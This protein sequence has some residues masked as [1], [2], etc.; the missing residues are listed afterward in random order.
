MRQ[1]EVVADVLDGFVH[2]WGLPVAIG[3]AVLAIA[4]VGAW[5]YELHVVKHGR[6]GGTSMGDAMGN[7]V[8]VF[9]P[10]QARAN[11]DL[12]EQRNVGPVSKVPERDPDDP[13]NLTLGPDGEPKS[14]RI[15]RGPTAPS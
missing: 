15:R 4:M 5:V 7:I 9:D 3:V 14:V 1:A 13:I 6:P 8:D 11:R 12:K 2:S 10:G